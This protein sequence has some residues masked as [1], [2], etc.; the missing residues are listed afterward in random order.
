MDYEAR[1][2]VHPVC[3]IKAPW[4]GSW[5]MVVPRDAESCVGVDEIIVAPPTE[6]FTLSTNDNRARVDPSAAREG[7]CVPVSIEEC[8][9]VDPAS[10]AKLPS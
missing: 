6:R 4:N 9:L 7:S 10:G 2:V 5:S 1:S 3:H 8:Y